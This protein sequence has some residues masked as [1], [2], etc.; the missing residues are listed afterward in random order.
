MIILLKKAS[1][2]R[3]YPIHHKLPL[4]SQLLCIFVRDFRRVYKQRGIFPRRLITRI[5]KRFETSFSRLIK[6]QFEFTRFHQRGTYIGVAYIREAY[7]H[8]VL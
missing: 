7:I 2:F 3:N 4:I 8:R 6:I 5:E 1:D